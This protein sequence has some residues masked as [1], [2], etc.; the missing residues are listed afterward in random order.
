MA[1]PPGA[2]V[3][4]P[5]PTSV[6]SALVQLCAEGGGHRGVGRVQA[7]WSSCPG[8]LLA[9]LGRAPWPSD[10]QEIRPALSP[11]LL[12]STKAV[13]FC[14]GS[15]RPPRPSDAVCSG[16]FRAGRGPGS[17]FLD[18]PCVPL[19]LFPGPAR[20]PTPAPGP[21]PPRLRPPWDRDSCLL[22]LLDFAGRWGPQPLSG[23]RKY[24]LP[25]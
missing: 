22:C 8:T 17:A 15:A 23:L 11:V 6:L 1:P 9:P 20:S 24:E 21:S 25:I 13:R 2:A 3:Q 7:R 5:C 12:G 4:G 16:P 10:H 19:A 14:G 18:R